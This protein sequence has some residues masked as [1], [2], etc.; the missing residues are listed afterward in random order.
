MRRPAL[1]RAVGGVLAV[2]PAPALAATPLTGSDV[3]QILR[4]QG[5]HTRANAEG[6][7][8]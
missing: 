6:E 5:F 8:D 7:S 4:Q 1:V 2:S 3:P